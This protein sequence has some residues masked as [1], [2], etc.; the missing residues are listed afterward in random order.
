MG[1]PAAGKENNPPV[2]TFGPSKRKWVP[3]GFSI[4]LSQNDW[5]V[6]E[7]TFLV[8]FSIV[9]VQL[10]TIFRRREKYLEVSTIPAAE[11]VTAGHGGLVW[12]NSS[13]ITAGWGQSLTD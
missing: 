9:I 6:Q 4:I 5:A 2:E 1:S 3:S 12:E 10:K 8:Y 13:G 7:N 11:I